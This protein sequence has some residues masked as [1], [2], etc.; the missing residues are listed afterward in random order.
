M[1]V[2]LLANK[3]RCLAED[4]MTEVI[5]KWMQNQE[6]NKDNFLIIDRAKKLKRIDRDDYL[7]CKL[8]EVSIKSVSV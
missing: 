6:N 2:K 1:N 5:Q 3:D 8:K 7:N 4:W